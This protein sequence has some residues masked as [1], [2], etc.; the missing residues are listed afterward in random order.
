MSQV[1]RHDILKGKNAFIAGG[2]SG[3]N[4][5]IARRL[6]EHGA[7]VVLLGRDSDKAKAAQQGL[8]ASGLNAAALCADVRDYAAVDAALAEAVATI[9]PLDIVVSGAA[10]N[11]V[12][13]ALAMSTN[14]F[15][16]VVDIDLI[17]TFNVCRASFAHLRRPG[18]VVLTITA[19]QAV[20]AMF[21]QAHV[22]AAKAG[23]NMLTRSLALEWGPA[24]VRVIGISPGPV[25]DTEGMRRLTPTQEAVDALCGR[26]PLRRYAE[27]EEI[28]DLALFLATPAARYITGA[29]IECDGGS[30]LGDASADAIPLALKA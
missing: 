26:I 8:S 11:F 1:F 16:A 13:P 24:G 19:G 4:L 5:A 29:I 20:A 30:S 18:A 9:G 3:I 22:S 21:G 27:A 15:R 23:V 14:G 7:S 2:T 17:G 6:A 12:A 28:G 10:G 25:A